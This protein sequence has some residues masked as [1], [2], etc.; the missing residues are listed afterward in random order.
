[1]SFVQS[2][3]G[4]G[5]WPM[6]VFLTPDLKPF[7][8]GTY[9]PPTSRWGRPG[10]ADLLAELARVWRTD[11]AKVHEA[12]TELL[13]RLKS[14]TG[15]DGRSRAAGDLAGTEALDV[16][17]EQF[18][19]AFDRKQGGFGDAPK[20]P[21][22]SELLFLLREHARRKAGGLA[23]QAPL[24]MVTD[25][26]RAMAL[27]G[28][29][30]QIGGG[31]HRYSVD[32]AWR[33]PHFEKM[34]YDQAQLVMAYLEAGQATGDAFFLDVATDTLDYVL[35][36]MTDPLG[37][38]YSAQD[39]DSLPPEAVGRPG[40]RKMEGAF[41]IWS[42][43]E[44]GELLGGDAE[45]A[46]LR[47]G[48]EPE[49]NAPHDPQGEFVGKNLLYVA[50]SVSD[51]A[52]RLGL[53]E[54]DVAAAVERSSAVLFEARRSRSAPDLDDK[55]LTAW[56]GLMVAAFARAA[57][58]LASSPSARRYRHAARR[59]AH[60]IRARLWLASEG[61]LL[62]RFRDGEAAI[63]GYAED[64][65]ALIHGLLELFQLE[66]DH[67]W[68]EWILE[69]QEKQRVLF[70]D[71]ADG[72]WFSTTG[73]DPNVLLR[74]KEDHDGAEP[75]AGSVTTNNLITLGHLLGGGR[76]LADAERTLARYGTRAGSAARAIPMMM[77]ALSAWH[78]THSQVVVVGDPEHPATLALLTELSRHY[79]PFAIVVPIAPG[80]PQA[81]LAHHLPF[82]SAMTP[83]E[84]G[85]AAYVCRHF[86]CQAPVSDPGALAAEL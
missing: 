48:I 34:L 41:Y 10:F 65:A 61:R 39:A 75:S 4:S 36:E 30:D 71:P 23:P 56:N 84:R 25:T 85:A 29:R 12:A 73:T 72:G 45:I 40:A 78:A 47:F 59:A 86:S 82:V 37:G 55:I 1:M 76:Y 42:D 66:G 64:Y 15:T 79:Q 68:L 26:L 19:M 51:I 80:A 49:G 16:A 38:F 81:G 20:F 18:Q 9:F 58:V 33:V 7:Y 52:A 2:T 77:A 22:P 83:G 13:A 62:R 74:L 11:R 6:S 5:G 21:R 3:T 54:A 24:V 57:R 44:I 8:G 43:A 69:L 53:P 60:F 17:V 50:Q 46:R 28:M 32:A 14:V 67:T 31:F 27:G 63:D 35:R 70:H